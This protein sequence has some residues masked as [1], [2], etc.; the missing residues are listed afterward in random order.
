VTI[1]TVLGG[2]V[3]E[4]V[5]RQKPRKGPV[6]EV[7]WVD[8]GGGEVRYSVEGWRFVVSMR[9][10]SAFRRMRKVCKG[11]KPK[12]TDEFTRQDVN[13]AYASDDL[14]NQLNKGVDHYSVAP[15]H[16][17]VFECEHPEPPVKKP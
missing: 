6:P 13:V 14:V 4:T 10:S 17:I 16:H 11:L 2:C 9:R 1:V 12:I 5:A 7:G 15:F 8:T 3:A